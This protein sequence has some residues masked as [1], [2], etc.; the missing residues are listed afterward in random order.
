MV[1]YTDQ[2]TTTNNQQQTT[3]NKQE[4]RGRRVIED[5]NAAVLRDLRV[6]RAF[7]VK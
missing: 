7:G 6:L 3:N 5:K 1:G 4:A 2:R